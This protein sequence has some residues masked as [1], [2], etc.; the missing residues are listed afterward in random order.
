MAAPFSTPIEYFGRGS[1]AVIQLKSSEEGKTLSTKEAVDERGDVIARSVYGERATPSG[2]YEVKASGDLD[3]VLG[4]VN[5]VS[6]VVYCVTGASITLSAGKPPTVKINGEALQNGATVSSTITIPTIA[7]TTRHKAADPLSGISLTGSG[8]E[9]NECTIDATCNFSPA[10][11]AGVIISHDVSGG[12]VVCK[13]KITQSTATPPT[14]SAGAGFA[15]TAPLTC[16][17]PDED[18]PTWTVEVTDD[19]ASV[20]PA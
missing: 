8:C 5:T 19:L 17:N 4:A 15:I 9:I 11:V 12:K 16:S 13:Y 3:I 18:Y 20:E 10:T 6:S 7:M 2:E 14:V 1:D